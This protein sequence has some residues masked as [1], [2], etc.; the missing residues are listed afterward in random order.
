V[1]VGM[2]RTSTTAV[3][4]S[5]LVSVLGSYHPK[6]IDD[7][8]LRY[9]KLR[10]KDWSTSSPD[11]LLMNV[12]RWCWK[13]WGETMDAEKANQPLKADHNWFTNSLGQQWI[14]IDPPEMVLVGRRDVKRMWV[15]IGRRY[16]LSSCEVTG[17]QFSAFLDD[18]RV[19]SWMAEDRTAR[20]ISLA[21]SKS[22]QS[23]ISW[24]MGV[25][26]CQW[27]NE[28]EN[29]P[30]DQWCY[31]NAWSDD[32]KNQP[33]ETDYLN[34]TGY[35]LPTHAEWEWACAGGIED[36]WHFGSDESLIAAYEWTQNQMQNRPQPVASLRPNWCGLFDMGGNLAEWMDDNSRPPF[37]SNVDFSIEDSGNSKRAYP[38]RVLSGGR[39]KLRAIAATTDS[40]TL[41]APEYLSSTTGLR[42]A[43]TIGI[44]ADNR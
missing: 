13:Q 42:L 3:Q 2:L 10:I 33:P 34:R 35:R 27:L 4:S 17:D 23:G 43:R 32:G 36:A 14:V 19:Q 41:N 31:P 8:N 12:S 39:F 30:K 6:D 21:H 9:A 26:Y 28:R 37:R 1:I 5:A 11:A 18:S 25:R 16:A 15:K 38:F 20:G 7:T 24:Q 44:K 40:F 29:I 22:P